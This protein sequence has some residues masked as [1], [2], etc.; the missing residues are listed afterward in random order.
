MRLRRS[1]SL[2]AAAVAAG[3]FVAALTA[4]AA[5]AAQTA[6][7]PRRVNVN[8]AS[9]TQLAYLPRIG[10]K[11]AGRIVEYRKQHGPFARPEDL[12]EVKGI[13]E[14]L[15]LSLKP[16][17]ALSGP[18]TLTEKVRLT[19]RSAAATAPPPARKPAPAAVPVGK[20]R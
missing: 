9:V 1:P 10:G 4:E 13:G 11:A 14:K 5:K 16:Y 20:G 18:T 3:F 17:I 19:R 12:M 15:F 8:Q 6:P 7:V 2:A